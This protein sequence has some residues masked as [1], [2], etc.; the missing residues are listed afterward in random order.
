MPRPAPD[1]LDKVKALQP[2]ETA[3]I[4]AT[5]T[6]AAVLYNLAKLTGTYKTKLV[7]NGTN[8]TITRKS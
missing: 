2:H 5:T 6:N 8:R 4:P 7:D 3:L 1:W